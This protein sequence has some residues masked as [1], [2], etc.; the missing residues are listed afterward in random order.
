MAEAASLAF[1]STVI[2]SLNLNNV[3]YLSDREQLVHFL[4]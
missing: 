2:D 3:N 4:N 1:A